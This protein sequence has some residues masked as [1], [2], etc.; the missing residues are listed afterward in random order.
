M[1]DEYWHPHVDKNNTS[2][3][4]YSGLIYL[5]TQGVDFT[6]GSLHFFSP[7]AL[8]CPND[9]A[10]GPCAVIAEPELTVA[11]AQGRLIVFGSGKENPHRVSRVLSGVRFVLSFWFTCDARR[12]MRNFLD[13]RQHVH[14]TPSGEAQEGQESQER[15]SQALHER[16]GEGEL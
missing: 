7:S 9:P 10:A 16:S 15:E 14:F 11:P 8:D 4:D 2:H 6:G 12:E 3:Y 5:S 13:G 1:H